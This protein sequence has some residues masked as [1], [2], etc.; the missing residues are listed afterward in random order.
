MTGTP[1]CD[2]AGHG[3]LDGR[4]VLGE[5][6][7]H[8]GAL[9]DQV[10]D[11]A[12]LGLGRR[13]G[14]VRDVRAA[15]GL[16]GRLDG[17]LVPLGPALFLVVVPR[18]ADGATAADARGRRRGRCRRCVPPR[19]SLAVVVVRR[20]FL[21]SLPHAA[22]ISARPTAE[23]LPALELAS[24][25]SPL[26]VVDSLQK[27]RPQALVYTEPGR[28]SR[29]NPDIA[30]IGGRPTTG[31][32]DRAVPTALALWFNRRVPRAGRRRA[33]ARARR[34]PGRLV[35]GGVVGS[36][37]LSRRPRAAAAVPR[38]AAPRTSWTTRASSGIDHRYQGEFEYFVGGGVAAF[39]CDGDGRDD[40]FLAG[41]TEPAALYRNDS[42]DRRRAALRTR[43]VA[44]DRSHR[45]HRRLPD[46]HR[47]R[48]AS[49][50]SSCCAAVATSC[51]A[52]SATAGSSPPTSSSASTAAGLDDGVQRDV[53]G[54][55]R[56]ADAGVRPLP[57]A[58]TR[59][60]A[61]RAGCVRPDASGGTV[62]ARRSRS[63]PGYCTL[64]MLFSD[65]SH[66]GQR[67]L[68]VSNDR[69]YYHDGEEQLWRI[70]PGPAADAVHRG[71]RLAPA[72]DLGHG[73][74]QPGRHRRR[75][76]RGVPH[77]P[78]R[79]QAADAGQ[80]R[81]PARPTTT[82]RCSSGVTAQRPFAGGD[83]LPST[84]WH[85][86]FADVNND[87]IADL[88][89][90]KGNVDAQIDQASRD[91]NN[92][93]IGQPD[94]TF[95]EGA[96]AAGIVELR[97]GARRGRRRPQP[98][99]PARPRRRRTAGRTST[100]WRNVGGGDADR[101]AAMGHWI[102]VAAAAAG[103]ER[104]RHRRLAR[105]ARSATARPRA[106]SRSAAGTPAASSAGST[107]GSAPRRAPRSGCSGP[108]ARSG[109]G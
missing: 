21:L 42:A 87:G 103:A 17:R 60:A 75:P 24:R 57:R 84:A 14:V 76:P 55:E 64:S 27:R 70:A 34:R 109:R 74:R 37:L 101:P 54:R 107:P 4:A 79:Q 106:R 46:R 6:D 45:G 19:G 91:P 100:L 93:L 22:R 31:G 89:V 67:D 104:R 3:R 51:C 96:E 30:R 83:V 92:L 62:R 69:H 105:R 26:D 48:R 47:Q 49:S 38:R 33:D 43:A 66:T 71:R 102:D 97:P 13:L 61:T 108:T 52:A 11:V 86:E 15:A 58:R 5:H 65:W 23:L 56:A 36:R 90:T 9:R 98:R 2:R 44:R 39:D 29:R 53:G 1:A 20:L 41:G 12:G 59:T 7:Q 63:R 82:S 88:F 78:G 68:R 80:R 25:T 85:P 94:G 8:L 50:T 73:H 81:R 40:L 35:L 77:Q 16:D 72:A 32:A 99:R 28:T 10:L 18:H 95:V